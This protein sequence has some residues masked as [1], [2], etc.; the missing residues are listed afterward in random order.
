MRNLKN[1]QLNKIKEIDSNT[2]NKLMV[3]GGYGQNDERD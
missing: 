3:G 2:E 1:I